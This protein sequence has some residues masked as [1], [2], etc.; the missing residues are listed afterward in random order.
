MVPNLILAAVALS[1]TVAFSREPFGPSKWGAKPVASEQ[2]Q[3]RATF[4]VLMPGHF[5]EQFKLDR[6]EIVWVP[7]GQPYPSI[8]PRQ[9][10]A[11]WY[12]I[13]K[14]KVVVVQTKALSGSRPSAGEYLQYVLGEGYF[15]TKQP[16]ACRYLFPT[17]AGSTDYCLVGVNVSDDDLRALSAALRRSS[18]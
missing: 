14:G 12:R 16:D 10:V 7:R 13:G 15:Y 5:R 2:L 1:G 11:L 17:T 3:A 6:A 9:A 18:K 8:T 4:P